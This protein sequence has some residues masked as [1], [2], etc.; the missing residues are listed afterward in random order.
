MFSGRP[1]AISNMYSFV[2]CPI[3][4]VNKQLFFSSVSWNN[5]LSKI[6]FHSLIPLKINSS[7]MR[8]LSIGYQSSKWSEN[9]LYYTFYTKT[10]ESVKKQTVSRKMADFKSKQP[11]KL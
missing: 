3:D 9:F 6:N 1:S 7:F 2:S 10:M 4:V 5:P 8:Y 11:P